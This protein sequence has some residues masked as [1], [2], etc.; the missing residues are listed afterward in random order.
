MGRI[1]KKEDKCG[2][3]KI[4]NIINGKTYIGQ[5][6]QAFSE[7]LKDHVRRGLKA[8]PATSN[9]LYDAMWEDGI[10]NFTFEILC[11][12]QPTELNEKEIYFIHFYKS[13]EWGYNI[14]KGG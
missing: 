8:E 10:E 3:Y 5:T 12:C 13:T 4:T 11:K 6:K 1:T 14:K 7:R 2:I 9:K